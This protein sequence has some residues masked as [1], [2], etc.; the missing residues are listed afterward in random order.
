M[1]TK[2]KET[3]PK[4]AASEANPAATLEE[5]QRAAQQFR[6]LHFNYKEEIEEVLKETMQ[7][8]KP[9][10]VL[11]SIK[12]MRNRKNQITLKLETLTDQTRK[13]DLIFQIEK[14]TVAAGF[15]FVR[16]EQENQ[17]KKK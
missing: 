12:F 10:E 14:F 17:K 4:A 3:K 7:L 1:A 9:A 2:K 5:T 11:E 6:D 15:A 16:D 8:K 13:E